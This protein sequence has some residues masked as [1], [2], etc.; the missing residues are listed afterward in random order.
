MTKPL[1]SSFRDPSGYIF[2][3]G[4]VI[5][6][7]INKSY[8][9]N[10]DSL[11]KSGLFDKLVS[12]GYLIGHKQ[13]PTPK[14]YP[15]VYITIQPKKIPFISY[16]YEWCFSMLKAASL[17]TLE[18]QKTA[19]EY[20]MSLK[21][22]SAF[23]IQFLEGKP[24][25]IDTL[26]FE[27]YQEGK[28]WI[29]YKQFV[30]HFL[31]PLALMSMADIR[32]NRLATLFIDGIPV[33]L[34]ARLLP[35]RSKLKLSLLLHIHAHSAGQKKFSGR[36]ITGKETKSFSRKAFLGLLDNLES[37]VKGLS[38]SP[39]E[40]EWTDYYAEN[41][42]NYTDSTLRQK[43]EAVRKFVKLTKPRTVWDIG[44]NTGA[45]SR[46]AADNQALVIALDADYGALEKNYLEIVSKREK[47]IL[48]LFCDL[49]NPTPAV[50]W[51]NTERLSIFE[52]G[53]ADL[54]LALALLHHLAIARN[55]PFKLIASL[56]SKLATHLIIEFVP[57]GDSQVQKLLMNREDIFPEYK[58]NGF[59]K[60]FE[61]F[62]QIK[63]AI[64][65]TNSQRI[66]YLME[67]R[68]K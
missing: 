25:L 67:K 47:N 51:A 39:K 13:V 11:I 23:N 50:G 26:S 33:G 8:R 19:L 46:I 49:V 57:K 2:T 29:A 54:V 32:L 42:H 5:F 66:I 34:A 48:P 37:T 56:F 24:I 63:K 35:F 20:N 62:F 7:Q 44:A 14:N 36:K 61:E 17:L 53:P 27:S 22:A 43:A 31:A 55:I 58:K 38:W 60:A 65:L 9:Q 30:E 21:D 18:I 12:S 68:K 10:Y 3:S 1:D 28:P 41:G 40:T 64:P 4:G 52:R 45:F 16:P 59:E 6:R 15:N